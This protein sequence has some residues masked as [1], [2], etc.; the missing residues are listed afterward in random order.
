MKNP[1]SGLINRL[2]IIKKKINECEDRSIGITK[3]E[4]Q[5]NKERK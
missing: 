5:S 3:S 2:N 1:F 4:T